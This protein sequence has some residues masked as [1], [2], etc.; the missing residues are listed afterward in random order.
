MSSVRHR[1]T[2]FDELLLKNSQLGPQR[3]FSLV[4]RLALFGFNG[5][6]PWNSLGHPRFSEDIND[7][8][9]SFR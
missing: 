2:L 6:W 1:S 3:L 7:T 5:R 8:S 9:F 4:P